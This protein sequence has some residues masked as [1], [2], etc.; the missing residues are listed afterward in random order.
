VSSGFADVFEGAFRR[1]R[2]EV[3][4]FADNSPP[5]NVTFDVN[6]TVGFRPG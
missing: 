5:L 2:D 6:T 3:R 1:E 4:D